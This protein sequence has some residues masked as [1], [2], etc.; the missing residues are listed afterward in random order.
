MRF[1]LGHLIFLVHL[2]ICVFILKDSGN[3]VLIN[4]E[5][6]KSKILPRRPNHGDPLV[7]HQIGVNPVE[8]APAHIRIR[9][10]GSEKLYLKQD[11]KKTING[12]NQNKK[13]Y[14]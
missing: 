10:I 7:R 6:S 5:G 3:A 8:V 4:L 13:G 9:F 2:L 11:L 12:L 14:H 1:L